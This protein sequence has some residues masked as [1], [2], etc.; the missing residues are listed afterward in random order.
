MSRRLSRKSFLAASLG[1]A[2]LAS[3]GV[4]VS[5]CSSKEQRSG[6]ASGTVELPKFIPF[7]AVK[8]DFPGE[9]G[10]ATDLFA[11]YPQSPVKMFSA[12][13]GDGKPLTA[14]SYTGN[15][16][17]AELSKNPYWQAMNKAVGSDLQFTLAP[18]ESYAQKF[19]T[20][21]AGNTLPDVFAIKPSQ[22]PSL[23][24]FLDATAADLTPY[25]SGDAV[26][27]FP[28][29]ANLSTEAW[30]GCVFNGKI[31][32][33]PVERG[34]TLTQFMYYRKDL[35]DAAG[36][37]ADPKNFEDFYNMCKEV[38]APREN[39]WA[40]AKVPLEYVRSM[41][42][43]APN[44][45]YENGKL[46]SNWQSDKQPE[47]LEATRRLFADGLM[48]PDVLTGPKTTANR[49]FGSGACVFIWDTYSAWGS[50]K[51]N[52][53]TVE[54]FELDGMLV[55]GF[56]G[57]QGRPVRQVPIIN[58]TGVN[59]ASKDRLE[60]ILKILDW[61]ATPFGT[62]EYLLQRYGVP[63]VHYN[64]VDGNPIAVKELQKNDLTLGDNY[65]SDHPT[66]FFE[67]G[68]A[69]VATV[70]QTHQR[71]YMPTTV[72]DPTYGYFS[73]T[74]GRK[75]ASLTVSIANLQTDIIAGRKPVSAWSAGVADIMKS[76]G[77]Q[78]RRE[79]ETAIQT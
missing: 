38:T 57:G 29:L 60:T 22:V 59:A 78:I 52:F 41:L 2:A 48:H 44:W 25:L 50:L 9:P 31:Y 20:V 75:L 61:L 32:A 79:F 4:G 7:D 5:G 34:I 37:S 69:A 42:G 39:R 40:L 62:E 18:N 54:T 66:V 36:I 12:P 33:I 47:A 21:V 10:I 68:D 49:W 27:K 73:E 15:P 1:T 23:P 43:I 63:G 28:A 45:S 6:S 65:L 55:P 56:D 70:R 13:P 16:P 14:L 74:A 58:I 46:T 67:P 30:K 11:K 71:K 64:L 77:E 19:A 76:D 51:A 8:P 24:Q 17:P 35:L 26:A 53:A 72:A 3:A